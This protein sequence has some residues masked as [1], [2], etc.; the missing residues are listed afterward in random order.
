MEVIQELASMN[1]LGGITG[2][3]VFKEIEETLIHYK[4]KWNLLRCVTTN[5]DKK[6]RGVEK[7]FVKQ[8]HKPCDNEGCLKPVIINYIIHQ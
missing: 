7:V 2:K 1:N 6:T 3:N 8:I 5:A 4:L